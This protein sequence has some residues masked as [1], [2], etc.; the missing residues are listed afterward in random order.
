LW[1]DFWIEQNTFAVILCALRRTFASQL[2]QRW[3]VRWK[4]IAEHAR[5]M[6]FFT[7]R[8]SM[9]TSV[10]ELPL[11]TLLGLEALLIHIAVC[12]IWKLPLF[13]DHY[14]I[15]GNQLRSAGASPVMLHHPS[16]LR[17]FHPVAYMMGFIG[18]KVCFQHTIQMLSV[19]GTLSF[20]QTRQ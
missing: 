6:V 3:I 11:V 8:S 17:C 12:V 20:I 14:G 1:K 10:V 2:A 16:V 9:P 7:T 18:V 19:M 15:F 13:G 4:F 5:V